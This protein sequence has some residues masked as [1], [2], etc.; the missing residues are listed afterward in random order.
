MLAIVLG[1]AT[2]CSSWVHGS[3]VSFLLIADVKNILG[4]LEPIVMLLSRDHQVEFVL[5][6]YVFERDQAKTFIIDP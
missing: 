1:S 2:K 5:S 6:R 4:N 3:V